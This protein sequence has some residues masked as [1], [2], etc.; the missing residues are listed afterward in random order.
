M[1]V[2]KGY[3]TGSLQWC[4]LKAL[5]LHQDDI[6]VRDITAGIK[7]CPN[8]SNIVNN[9]TIYNHFMCDLKL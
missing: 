8:M 5:S 2:L 9:C 7:G 1:C 4:M 3:C 6:W